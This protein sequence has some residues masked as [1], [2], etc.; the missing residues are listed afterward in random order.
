MAKKREKLRP[1]RFWWWV[2]QALCSVMVFF[3]YKITYDRTVLKNRD[4]TKGCIFL[5]NHNTVRDHILITSFL[6][7]TRVNF[8]ITKRFSFNP[9]TKII[10][11][12]VNTV[13]RDQFK[14][15]TA[16]ILKM[17]RILN[18]SGVVMISPA[19]QVSSDGCL[20]YI[21]E[22]IVKLIKLCKVDVYTVRLEGTYLNAPKWSKVKRIYP[23][24]ISSKLTLSSDEVINESNDYC[25]NALIKD[26]NVVDHI[27][28][29]DKM[30]KIK[31]KDLSLGLNDILYLCPKCHSRFTLETANNM[32]TCTNCQNKARIN[33]YGYIE[34]VSDNYLIFR[35]EALWY[36]YQ[37]NVIINNV[38]NKT[39]FLKSEVSVFSDEIDHKTL[40]EVGKGVLVLDNDI[41]YY[42]GTFMNKSYHKDFDLDNI[43]QLPFAPSLRFNIPNDEHFLEFVPKNLQEVIVWVQTIDSINAYKRSIKESK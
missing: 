16:S 5:Y 2:Y 24:H 22:S 21:N 32:I 8:I 35:T 30:I 42:E 23:I 28:Q 1:N 43:Y 25:Y 36:D 29:R 37:K 3:N 19:G 4:K 13:P 9:F 38:K 26:I 27:T 10:L 31:G 12:L 34:G 40:Q 7:M 20:P 41:F 17:K 6:R 33:Q 14:S 11:S 18:N 15:D 39:L